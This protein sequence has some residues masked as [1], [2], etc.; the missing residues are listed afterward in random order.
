MKIV[1]KLVV[2]LLAV[3]AWAQSGKKAQVFSAEQLQTENS[4]LL[5]LA[6]QSGSS[7]LTLGDYSTH[8]LMLSDRTKSGGAEMH[9][10]F[11]DILV[12]TRG[13]AT[14]ITGGTIPDSQTDHDGETKGKRIVNGQ[15]RT[16]SKGDIV[17][18][19]AGTP[20]QLLIAPGM[21]FSALVVKV[22]E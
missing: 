3:P 16:I 4:R 15:S 18:I 11:D 14:L 1:A 22:H 2:A 6:E 20:H 7:G 13:G 19:P 17:H 21:V 9:A 10:H 8:K 12:I 5:H